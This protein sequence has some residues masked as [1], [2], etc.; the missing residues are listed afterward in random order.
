MNELITIQGL[1]NAL[2]LS[3]REVKDLR[4]KL[5]ITEK[6]LHNYVIQAERTIDTLTKPYMNFTTRQL[7]IIAHSLALHE[8]DD[9]FK[10]KVEGE[11]QDILSHLQERG[12]WGNNVTKN[13]R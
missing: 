3:M 4:D 9:M 8:N 7:Q 10:G 2:N 13:G 6:Y 11:M 5:E 12:I 1:Q